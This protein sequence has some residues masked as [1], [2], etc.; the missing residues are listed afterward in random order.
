MYS[1][2]LT[3]WI[4]FFFFYCF[5]GWIWECFYVSLNQGLKTR[6]WKFINRGFLKGKKK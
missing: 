2:S 5:L 6:N 1:Y 3:E 4:L